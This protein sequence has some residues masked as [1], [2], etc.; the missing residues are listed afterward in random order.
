MGTLIKIGE[1]GTDSFEVTEPEAQAVLGLMR[2]CDTVDLTAELAKLKGPQGLAAALAQVQAEIPEVTKGEE[3]EV[4]KDGKFLYKYSY[5][6]LSAVTRAIL[7]RLGSV[8]LSW[9]TMPTVVDGKF[10]LV[11]RLQHASGDFLEGTYPLPA[12]LSPQQTGSAITYARRYCLCSVTGIAP[13]DDDDAAEAQTAYR[14]GDR[15]EPAKAGM[16]AFEQASGIALLT[17]PTGEQRKATPV[18]TLHAA[19]LQALD[20]RH[21][22]DEHKAWNTS[23][24]VDGT[25]W[26]VLLAQRVADEIG[27]ADTQDNVNTL[28]RMLKAASYNPEVEGKSMTSRIKERA[29]AI[30]ARNAQVLDDLGKRIVNAT[31]VGELANTITADI[32]TAY[33]S[34]HITEA[35]SL[36]LTRMLHD[37]VIK[38]QRSAGGVP[39][40]SGDS[41]YDEDGH[42]PTSPELKGEAPIDG[43]DP[44][45]TA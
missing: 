37:R 22:L 25:T 18:S 43:G 21:C 39:D 2:R 31:E 13:S 8:G 41:A 23:A 38:L 34:Y 15:Q 12:G 3:G 6:D 11:Y 10:V 42:K 28:W 30:V 35:E 36:D 24:N 44:W 27:Y 26:G 32:T 9:V 20:F 29:A 14:N 4:V 40:T 33:T 19:L 7:P 16:S 17:P 5:A 45:A 1:S